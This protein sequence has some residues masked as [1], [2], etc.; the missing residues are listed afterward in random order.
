MNRRFGFL[1]T[2]LAVALMSGSAW[3]GVMTVQGDSAPTY[4]TTLNF[5]EVGGPPA[6]AV[7]GDEWQTS[8]GVTELVAGNGGQGIGNLTGTYPWLPNNNVFDGPFGVFIKFDQDLTEFSMQVWDNAGP[9]GGISGGALLAVLK[10]GV[11]IGGAGWFGTPAFG[12]N[13]GSWFN[14][15]TS[16]G[17]T[18]DEVRFLGFGFGFPQSIADNL[19]WNAVPEP[20]SLALL[21]MT[22]IGVLI[23]R[24]R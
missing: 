9:P 3:A 19:S 8:H 7:V 23:R 4:S 12:T 13:V 16:G 20:G 15:T 2:V 1:A 10:D 24:R 6:G 18:F 17:D 22:G 5:D 21:A 11:E 14:I